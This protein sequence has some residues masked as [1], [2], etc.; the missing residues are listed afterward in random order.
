MHDEHQQLRPW[1]TIRPDFWE[2]GL[3]PASGTVTNEPS[4]PADV[5][6]PQQNPPA[7]EARPSA[8]S[9]DEPVHEEDS[10]TDVVTT[11]E[12]AQSAAS[13]A[14]S[15]PQDG[16][17]AAYLDRINSLVA[18]FGRPDDREGLAAAAVEAETIDQ[19]L[20]AQ[21]GDQHPYTINIRE[22][23]GWLAFLMGD[24][25]TAARWFLHTTG[26]QIAAR[27]AAHADTGSSVR[28][29]VHTWQQVKDPAE[30]VLIGG[31]LAKAVAAV[32]GE[33]SDAARFVQARIARRHKQLAQ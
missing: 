9:S 16:P 14:A 22:I 18:S 2:S 13:S 20:T 5:V 32:L 7:E 28:R 4:R 31:D 19:E 27:G 12:A 1:G 8:S 6:P 15:P 33:E 10:R 24:S 17:P 23:R 29:A 25:A 26:L 3:T 30:V 21:Y 11:A